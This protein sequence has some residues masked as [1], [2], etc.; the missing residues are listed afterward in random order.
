MKDNEQIRSPEELRALN[1]TRIA[2]EKAKYEAAKRIAYHCVYKEINKDMAANSSLVGYVI[3]DGECLQAFKFAAQ[4]LSD[5]PKNKEQDINHA[6]D[7]T[8][9]GWRKTIVERSAANS[10]RYWFQ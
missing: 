4:R 7:Y 8:P 2:K 10:L 1:D 6:F 9:F 5:R 3:L